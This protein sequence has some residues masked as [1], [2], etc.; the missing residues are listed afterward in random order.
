MPRIEQ[1]FGNAARKAP[2]LDEAGPDRALAL[3]Y[4]RAPGWPAGPGDPEQGLAHARRA[5]ELRPA[6]PPN[7][8]ALGEALAVTGDT[9]GSRKA[10]ARSLELARSREKTG[11]KE[12]AEWIEEAKKH[13]SPSP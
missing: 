4:L 3:F 1:A 12:A 6:Y 2:E 10:Y 11:D 13:L 9:E 7:L 8:L 5:I